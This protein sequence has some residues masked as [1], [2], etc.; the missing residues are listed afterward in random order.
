MIKH[1]TI[2][3]TFACLSSVLIGS[4]ANATTQHH[5][6]LN[7][8]ACRVVPTDNS[9]VSATGNA[10]QLG[11]TPVICDIVLPDD[12]TQIDE[13]DVEFT[14]G[15]GSAGMATLYISSYTFSPATG[16]SSIPTYSYGSCTVTP[17]VLHVAGC[18]VTPST[19]NLLSLQT[20][21]AY[22][23]LEVPNGYVAAAARRVTIWYETT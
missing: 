23:V 10:I 17:T 8:M 6:T 16:F 12:A 5:K 15:T 13:V 20:P 11:T 1:N 19:N 21:S 22:V 4:Q 2:A 9:T 7:A 18:T 14:G 3:V